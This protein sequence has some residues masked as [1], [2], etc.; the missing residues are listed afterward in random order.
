MVWI[1]GRGHWISCFIDF[2][3]LEARN[4]D[5]DK[6][7][8]GVCLL[9]WPLGTRACVLKTLRSVWEAGQSEGGLGWSGGGVKYK[10]WAEK[11]QV[12]AWGEGTWPGGVPHH[13]LQGGGRSTGQG[14]G[15]Q[16]RCLEHVETSEVVS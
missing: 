5:G 4:K 15:D 2:V 12:S 3:K 13:H 8:D 1:V 11:K 9:C 7:P 16:G 10:T 14:V 6:R